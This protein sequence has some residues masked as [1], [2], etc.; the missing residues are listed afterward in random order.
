M[1]CIKLIFVALY[2]LSFHVFGEQIIKLAT[3]TSTEN[4]GLLAHIL[5]VFERQTGYNVHV[6]A[7]GS[8]NALRLGRS[9]DVDLVMTHAPDAEAQ[10]IAQGFGVLPRQ[11]MQNDFVLLGPKD[12]PAKVQSVSTIVQAFRHIASEDVLFISRGDD[13]GTEKKELKLWLLSGVQ[14]TFDG[15]KSVGQG[16]GRTLLMADSLQAY[17]LSDRGTYITY[18]NKLDLQIVFEG[19]DQ[20]NNPYQVILIS[21]DKYPQLNHL[22]A[23]AL[24]DWLISDDGQRLINSYRLEQLP[25]FKADYQS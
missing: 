11:F 4:S 22:G 8:G 6:I 19:G 10:F 24:S 12:D 13:S 7:T 25:L 18:R 20:L 5:P 9:G 15:Y 2:S 23:K 21:A 1:R 14:P 3:T 16:M 17:T